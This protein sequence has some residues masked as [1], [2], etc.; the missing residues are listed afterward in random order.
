M[1][2]YL[3]LYSKHIPVRS[4][5]KESFVLNGMGNKT[6]RSG[7]GRKG[8]QGDGRVKEPTNGMMSHHRSLFGLSTVAIAILAALFATVWSPN[9]SS[10]T[11]SN[12]IVI[13][14]TT[15]NKV[16]DTLVKDARPAKNE[17]SIAM[18]HSLTEKTSQK[19]SL[20]QYL[21][22][23]DGYVVCLEEKDLVLDRQGVWKLKQAKLNYLDKIATS[24]THWMIQEG[25]PTLEQQPV[26]TCRIMT[27]TH[28][29]FDGVELLHN[30]LGK[31]D[32]AIF[33]FSLAKQNNASE[34]RTHACLLRL[35]DTVLKQ[36]KTML[37]QT[38]E[39]ATRIR[40]DVS[41]A[42]VA[43]KTDADAEPP[44][45]LQF[46]WSEHRTDE[47]SY[48]YYRNELEP[49]QLSSG[50]TWIRPTAKPGAGVDGPEWEKKAALI[51]RAKP[52]EW[53]KQLPLLGE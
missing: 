29:D 23:D 43:A 35:L 8:K 28:E 37:P 2:V 13:E 4:R 6:N 17:V 49:P 25:L 14:N 22:Y 32:S 1:I 21:H 24:P 20:V 47:K 10:S 50:T 5:N 42:A 46:G 30:V 33:D 36:T 26:S 3:N 7:K 18:F 31:D 34:Y 38:T 15:N 12:R 40:Y 19:N 39:L 41:V 27:L 16:G 53:E 52:C 44:S 51:V 9:A 11:A 48:S 45:R